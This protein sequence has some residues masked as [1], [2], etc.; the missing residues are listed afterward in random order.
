MI[1]LFALGLINLIMI[2]FSIIFLLPKG[3]IKKIP[4]NIKTLFEVFNQQLIPILI[5]LI[6]AI[7]HLIEVKF[8]DPAVTNWVGRDY[9]YFIRS[10]EGDIVIHFS[11]YWTPI[12][13]YYFVIIYIGVYT[14]TLWFSPL[15][16]ILG[17]KKKAMKTFAYGLLLI[18]AIS[19]P[20]YLFLPVTNVYSAPFYEGKSAL[21]TV[22]PSIE[23][24]FYSTTTLNNCFPSLHTAMSILVAYCA[25]LTGN[26]KYTYF[27]IIV[28]ISVIISVIYLSIHWI[29]DTIGGAILAF[30]VIL[31]LRRYI[32][33]EE[34]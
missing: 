6:V 29:L 4:N 10:I 5:I 28:M 3:S 34:K 27:I 12:L 9:S 14:F 24:F 16:F 18:Y 30:L 26:K 19:L 22:I 17:N 7:F 31:I 21:E 15:Y 1:W 11:N 13:I 8:I 20:F 23:S 32:K 2:I 25:S 33:D